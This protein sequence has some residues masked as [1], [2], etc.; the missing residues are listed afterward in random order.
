MFT[1]AALRRLSAEYFDLGKEYSKLQSKIAKEV[2]SITATY[3]PILE[4]SNE[5]VAELDVFL[6]FAEVA[7]QAPTQYVRPLVTVDGSLDLKAGR[8]ACV[9]VQDDVSFIENDTLLERNLLFSIITG[10]NMGGKS[11][12]IRQVLIKI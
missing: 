8:H 4:E 6:S 10:P 12:Y 2:I 11:T 9:E 5:L 3:F 1:T 7:F